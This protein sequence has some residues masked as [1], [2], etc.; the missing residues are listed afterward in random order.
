VDKHEQPLLSVTPGELKGE[1]NGSPA[2]ISSF[3]PAGKPGIILMLDASASMK[4]TWSQ[5][6]AAAKQLVGAAGEKIDTVVFGED[7]QAHAIGRSEGEKL[8]NQLSAQPPKHGATALYDALIEMA[9]R[10]NNRNA[11]IIVISDGEDN[12]SRHSLNATVS[13]FLHS[14]WPPVFGL[15]LDY[16]EI[17]R[18]RRHFQEIA[19][20]TGGLV[21]YPSSASKVS[22]ATEELM[23]T[24]QSAF[25]LT[26]QPSQPITK[27]AKLKLEVIGPDG[28]PRPDLRLLHSADVAG[29]DAAPG[30][31]AKQK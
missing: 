18:P 24:M 13:L 5:S 6:I 19:A 25:A 28:R 17:R 23:A 2:T 9:E 26:L 1:I 14:S 30:I 27:A 22:L 20:A 3:S 11:A 21:A 12:A 4:S 7:I 15:I 16:G 31:S 29:C 10:T 8:L